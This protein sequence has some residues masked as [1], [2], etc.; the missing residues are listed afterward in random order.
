MPMATI[1]T[2]DT[3]ITTTTTTATSATTTATTT[4][5]FLNYICI[6]KLV[7][8]YEI[9]TPPIFIPWTGPDLDMWSPLG[10][11]Q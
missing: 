5:Y 8:S 3:A 9:K 7:L 6:L 4:I 10:S 1:T 2:S 11:L